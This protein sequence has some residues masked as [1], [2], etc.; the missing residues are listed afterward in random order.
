VRTPDT[1]RRCDTVIP[2]VDACLAA[3]GIVAE[4]RRIV[5]RRGVAGILFS[6]RRDNLD[7]CDNCNYLSAHELEY[8]RVIAI[9]QRS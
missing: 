9:E 2:E 1:S 3:T 5:A 8:D 7:E 4:A 6:L